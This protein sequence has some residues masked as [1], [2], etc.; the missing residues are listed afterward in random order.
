[1][2]LLSSTAYAPLSHA[3][4]HWLRGTPDD[5]VAEVTGRL[6]ERLL[7]IEDLQWAD[8]QSIEV[9][10]RLIGRSRLALTAR[11]RSSLPDVPGL[12]VVDI[13]PLSEIAA[14]SL[15]HKLHPQ[16]EVHVAASW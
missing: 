15:V 5:V 6:G 16:L 3:V 8:G 1:M 12:V 4:H 9:L 7:V 2:P 10:G 14:S 11:D 13:D